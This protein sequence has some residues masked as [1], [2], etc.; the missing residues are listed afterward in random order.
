MSHKNSTATPQLAPTF[1]YGDNPTHDDVIGALMPAVAAHRAAGNTEQA[2]NY[3][4]PL[5]AIMGAKKGLSVEQM[6]AASRA[7]RATEGC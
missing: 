1:E 5:A 3:A 6:R 7:A 2:A 4:G